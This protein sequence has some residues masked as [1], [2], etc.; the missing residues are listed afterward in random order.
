MTITMEKYS[1]FEIPVGCPTDL[2]KR[3][4]MGQCRKVL[5]EM[6]VYRCLIAV[7]LH[8]VSAGKKETMNTRIRSRN[9]GFSCLRAPNDA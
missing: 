3:K 7:Q 5:W 2:Q 8:G 9:R 4:R 6:T 1:C